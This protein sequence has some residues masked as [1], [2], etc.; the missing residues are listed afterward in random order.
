MPFSRSESMF[1]FRPYKLWSIVPSIRVAA[2]PLGAT[3]V[4]TT[5][6]SG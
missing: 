5:V 4:V 6:E 3:L 1:M 2:T